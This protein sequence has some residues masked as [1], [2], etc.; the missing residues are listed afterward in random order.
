MKNQTKLR[1]IKN[2]DDAVVGVVVTVLLI[3]LFMVILV[4]LNTIYVPQWL[5]N[6]EAAHM[7]E[8]STQMA[9]LKYAVDVQSILD[10]STAITTSVVLGTKEIPFFDKGRTYDTL[11]IISDALTIKFDSRLSITT[12]AI[13]YKSGNS[14]FPNQ[15]FIYEAGTLFIKQDETVIPYANPSIVIKD[16]I[17]IYHSWPDIDG[18]NISFF[19]PNIVGLAGKTSVGGYGMYPIFTT[20]S[21]PSNDPPP[22]EDVDYIEVTNNYPEI[23]VLDAWEQ[24]FQQMLEQQWVYFDTTDPST[25]TRRFT[26]KV[27]GHIDETYNFYI[28][29]KDI[30]TQIAFGLAE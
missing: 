4:M 6:S 11:E 3:G 12:D 28:S 7:G 10:K 9:Q 26:F 22:L 27:A 24:V 8:V 13:V 20:T 21:G 29:T 16:Y 25:N 23:D 5:E 2:S 14:Y 1:D 18:A 15:V 30:N 17:N 19:I